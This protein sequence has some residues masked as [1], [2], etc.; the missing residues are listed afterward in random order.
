MHPPEQ[1]Y[2]SSASTFK[3]QETEHNESI[4]TEGFVVI[5]AQSTGNCLSISPFSVCD[6]IIV[7]S[8]TYSYIRN[9]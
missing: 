9:L 2:S 4:T 1:E 7:L 6:V 5:P 3:S 8:A